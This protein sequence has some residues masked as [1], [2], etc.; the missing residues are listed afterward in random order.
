MVVLDE[1]LGDIFWGP[2]M[3]AKCPSKSAI[4]RSQKE[5]KFT[6]S[7]LQRLNLIIQQVPVIDRVLTTV[8]SL[9]LNI[10][11]LLAGSSRPFY[12][13]RIQTLEGVF[14]YGM[15]FHLITW[16]W[17]WRNRGCLVLSF[18]IVGG[19]QQ[20][21]R[22]EVIALWASPWWLEHMKRYDCSI[23]SREVGQE[24]HRRF[25]WWSA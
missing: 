5:L 2:W 19:G 17:R 12:I 13:D 9:T 8:S 7:F 18:L 15:W 3:S 22:E 25:P 10:R 23:R 14:C 6:S 21:R 24:Y 11:A 1:P 16:R 4:Y 20:L